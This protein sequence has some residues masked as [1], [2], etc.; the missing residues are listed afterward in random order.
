MAVQDVVGELGD[1]ELTRGKGAVREVA[2]QSGIGCYEG[3]IE[4]AGEGDE[5]A[6]IGG[7]VGF[8]DEG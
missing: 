7:A 4:V 5:F 8:G 1:E 2:Q 3:N 6:V